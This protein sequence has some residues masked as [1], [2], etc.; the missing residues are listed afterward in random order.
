[1]WS[2]EM[3]QGETGHLSHGYEEQQ[4]GE[5]ERGDEVLFHPPKSGKGLFL[6]F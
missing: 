3:R 2:K 5:D 4:E 1:M 6:L